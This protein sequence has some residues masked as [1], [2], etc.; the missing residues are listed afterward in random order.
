[1]VSRKR[2]TFS[3]DYKAE[4][5]RMVIDESR[6]IARVAADLGIDDGT[7]GGWVTAY[8]RESRREESP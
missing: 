5:V 2:T 3:A 4:A 6:P 1:L 7:L 8:R